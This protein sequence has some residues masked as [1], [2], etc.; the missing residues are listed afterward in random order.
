MTI[1]HFSYLLLDVLDVPVRIS[2]FLLDVLDVPV[3][4]SDLLLD[5]LDVPVRISRRSLPQS[6]PS[7]L[8]LDIQSK[9]ESAQSCVTA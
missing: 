1:H 4:I 5:V 2:D 3:R 9:T 7:S 6:P 8:I